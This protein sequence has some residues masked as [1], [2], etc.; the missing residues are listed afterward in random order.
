MSRYCQ[1]CGAVCGDAETVCRQCGTPLAPMTP[2]PLPPGQNYAP[3]SMPGMAWFKFII[4][5]QLFA[6]AI[7]NVLY[8]IRCLSGTL[9]YG[10]VY[11]A[12]PAMSILDKLMGIVSLG[13]AVF[14][15]IVRMRLAKYRQN[16]PSSYLGLLVANFVTSLLYEIA[17]NVILYPAGFSDLGQTL[18]S[19]AGPLILIF[20]NAAYF[21]KRMYLFIY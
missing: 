4:Y 10:K 18:I 5:F 8:A 19:A 7:F 13:L 12:Y 1:K 14:G 20:I 11:A 2:P 9:L 15:I 6:F 17:T 16:G 21:K 3:Y